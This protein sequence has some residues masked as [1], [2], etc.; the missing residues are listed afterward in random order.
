[1][2]TSQRGFVI[3][4]IYSKLLALRLIE[5]ICRQRVEKHSNPFGEAMNDDLGSSLESERCMQLWSLYVP[6][7]TLWLKTEACCTESI[8]AA[9]YINLLLLTGLLARLYCELYVKP[10]SSVNDV[11]EQKQTIICSVKPIWHLDWKSCAMS[12][13]KHSLIPHGTAQ[14][15][16][17]WALTSARWVIRCANV[18]FVSGQECGKWMTA[19]SR[20][21]VKRSQTRAE[22][23]LSCGP[24]M[25]FSEG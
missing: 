15:K 12:S 21:M 22:F 13:W 1:M 7:E 17:L 10:C 24:Q 25:E 11:Q 23:F 2:Q 5:L 19:L 6:L 20:G 16:E 8:H 3:Q 9:Q 18:R 14:S 4:F